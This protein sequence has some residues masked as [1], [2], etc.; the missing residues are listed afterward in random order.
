MNLYRVR[1]AVAG[2]CAAAVS[3]VVDV[4]RETGHLITLVI[5]LGHCAVELGLTY[6]VRRKNLLHIDV[7][8]QRQTVH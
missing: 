2:V 1:V 8:F 6:A 7:F 4:I 5:E 3:L